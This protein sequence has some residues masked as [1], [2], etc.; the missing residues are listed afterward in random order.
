MKRINIKEFREKGYLQEV[1]RQLLHPLG[2]ALE[3]IITED[4]TE[5]LGGVWDYRQDPEGLIYDLENSS[6][7][8]IIKFSKNERFIESQFEEKVA[9]RIDALGFGV[10]QIPENWIDANRENIEHISNF[11]NL[12]FLE[13][14]R[15]DGFPI[16]RKNNPKEI[17]PEYIKSE[18]IDGDNIK[19][20]KIKSSLLRNM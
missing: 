10:E 9:E 8:R 3:V 12:E 16:C 5:S 1:N 7:E 2:L 13:L 20:L 17:S 6:Q 19:I 18:I 15:V 14:S 11:F 4:G